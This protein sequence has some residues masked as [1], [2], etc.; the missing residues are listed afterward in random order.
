MDAMLNCAEQQC[1]HVL[2][3][4]DGKLAADVQKACQQKCQISPDFISTLITDQI[5]LEVHNKVNEINL[6]IANHISDAVI[7]K[8]IIIKL[9]LF[10]LV[11]NIVIFQR[12]YAWL[13]RRHYFFLLDEVINCVNATSKT[14]SNDT[15][16]SLKKQR[17]RTPDVLKE[18]KQ[19]GSM[20]EMEQTETLSVTTAGSDATSQRSEPSPLN[21]PQ[22]S[23]KNLPMSRKLR[24]KSEVKDQRSG[25]RSNHPSGDQSLNEATPDVVGS[26]V[27]YSPNATSTPNIDSANGIMLNGSDMNNGAMD[28]SEDTVPELPSSTALQHLAKARPKRTKKHAPSRGAVVPR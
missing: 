9:I 6:I 5:G 25:I 23:K 22:P 10:L 15:V 1:P 4:K 13:I 7:G 26:F 28:N 19:Y 12:K 27:S 14:L 17:S 8:I 11:F 18:S 24:P 3:Q 20:S 21:T 16:G 2:S